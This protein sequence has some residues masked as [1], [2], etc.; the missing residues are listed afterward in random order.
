MKTLLTPL[1]II[2]LLALLQGC[3]NSPANKVMKSVNSNINSNRESIASIK[4]KFEADNPEYAALNIKYFGK[5]GATTLTQKMNPKFLT[6]EEKAIVLK[7]HDNYIACCLKEIDNLI[8]SP[9]PDPAKSELAKL[10]AENREMLELLIMG[11]LSEKTTI[12]EWAT[13]RAITI[14]VTQE[15]T[16]EVISR[17]N[18]RFQK[19]HK[20]WRE[21]MM[22]L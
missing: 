14:Q 11:A 21:L 12:G 13:K 8:S 9:Y 2:S 3:I 1:L 17:L 19:R 18:Q 22:D 7:G 6:E 10:L 20:E 15:K 5:D 16:D 4:D